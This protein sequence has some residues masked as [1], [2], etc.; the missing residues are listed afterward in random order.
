MADIAVEIIGGYRRRTLFEV[1]EQIVAIKFFAVS[2]RRDFN[3][4]ESKSTGDFYFCLRLFP[5][6]DFIGII[7]FIGNRFGPIGAKY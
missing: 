3:I 4:L 1:A 7:P 6:N 5:I 2:F